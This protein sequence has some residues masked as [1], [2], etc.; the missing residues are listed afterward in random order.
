MELQIRDPLSLPACVVHELFR[1]PFTTYTCVM[2]LPRSVVKVPIQPRP[3]LVGRR[4]RL[5]P[6]LKWTPT[7]EGR[8]S[9]PEVLPGPCVGRVRYVF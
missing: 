6:V 2:S 5:F 8:V 4:K 3:D 1:T 9:G 7:R